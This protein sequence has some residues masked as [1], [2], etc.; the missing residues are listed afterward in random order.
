M[1]TR[2]MANCPSSEMKSSG[3]NIDDGGRCE[4]SSFSGL[5]LEIIKNATAITRPTAVICLSPYFTPSM[6]RTERLYAD[7]RQ[8]SARIWYICSVVTK[9][10]RPCRI[11]VRHASTVIRLDVK[12]EAIDASPS[13]TRGGPSSSSASRFSNAPARV[14]FELA[15]LLA[16]LA[17]C[18]EAGFFLWVSP[19]LLGFVAFAL[20]PGI[21]ADWGCFV[22]SPDIKATPTWLCFKAPTSFVPSPHI[23]VMN[24]DSLKEVKTFSFSSGFMR[25][26]T[27]KQSIDF[28]VLSSSATAL[29]SAFPLVQRSYCSASC[30]IFENT[31]AF[32]TLP[33]IETHSRPFSRLSARSK[34]SVGFESIPTCLAT[35][36]AVSAES[37]VIMT[38]LWLEFTSRRTTFRES[39][40]SGHSNAMK[41]A[42]VRSFSASSLDNC[43]SSDSVVAFGSS[44]NAS[45]STRMPFLASPLAVSS[46]PAGTSPSLIRVL[47]TSADPLTRMRGAPCAPPTSRICATMLIRCSA[48]A[49]RFLCT[50]RSPALVNRTSLGTADSFWVYFQ[51]TFTSASSSSGSPTTSPFKCT[52]EWHPARIY[53]ASSE[54][55]FT[56]TSGKPSS[57]SSAGCAPPFFAGGRATPVARMRSVV[58]VPVLSKQHT[59]TLPANGMRKGSVQNTACFESA[60]SDALTAMASCMGSS[61][62]TTEV[63]IMMQCSMS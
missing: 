38:T 14:C 29:S 6:W 5:P 9:V 40:R 56:G 59:S 48:E 51:L 62:G 12:G 10:A 7:T 3:A 13:F 4:E 46:Y 17:G 55:S 11:I 50:M 41:P 37:P 39:G 18:C 35:C 32:F 43:L 20:A 22:I 63:T 57:L 1:L 27:L 23:R 28:H 58:R 49:K 19:A 25:A 16:F 44:L 60:T 2:C 21:T 34:I 54:P 8:L 36:A 52:K 30:R 15:K 24:P 61:G 47:M 31:N 45:A 42:N 33:F 53:A 26:K